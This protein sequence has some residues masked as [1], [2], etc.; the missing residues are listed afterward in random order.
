MASNADTEG[1]NIPLTGII[2]IV[3]MK[4]LSEG[5][6]RLARALSAEERARISLGMLFR[7][8]SAV[9]GAGLDSVWVVGGMNVSGNWRAT[10]EGR[11]WRSWAAI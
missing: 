5:K 7:V 4:P 3:P 1:G 11:G 10:S 6:S 2:A 8:L 9:R